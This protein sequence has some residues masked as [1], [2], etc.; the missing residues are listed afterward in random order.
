MQWSGFLVSSFSF[1][2]NDREELKFFFHAPFPHVVPYHNPCRKT[3]HPSARRGNDPSIA[4]RAIS[5]EDPLHGRD[6]QNN[7]PRSLREDGE[8]AYPLL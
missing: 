3:R 5:R 4:I 2:G 8:M 1:I 6:A 7:A